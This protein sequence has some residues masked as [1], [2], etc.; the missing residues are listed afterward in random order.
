MKAIKILA[1]MLWGILFSTSKA[2][3]DTCGAAIKFKW[4]GFE[5]KESS[6][7][8]RLSS[9][10]TELAWMNSDYEFNFRLQYDTV[11]TEELDT[12]YNPIRLSKDETINHLNNSK[13]K[14]LLVIWFDKSVMWSGPDKEKLVLDTVRTLTNSLGFDRVTI[15]GAHCCGIIYL[16]DTCLGRNQSKNITSE[17]DN[18]GKNKLTTSAG[19]GMNTR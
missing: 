4:Y 14:R 10:A 9:S 17:G 16:S 3:A 2:V 19:K 13:N 15:F 11:I 7:L 18:Y 8:F 1:L 12:L 6:D 5:T